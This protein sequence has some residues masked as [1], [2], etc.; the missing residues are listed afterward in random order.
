MTLSIALAGPRETV[1]VTDRRLVDGR[2]G[3]VYDEEAC[4]LAV[5]NC[6]DARAA[7]AYTGLACAKG[8]STQ[9]WLCDSLR[10]AA[11]PD[12]QL[13]PMLGRLARIATR[14]VARLGLP[15]SDG[16]LSLIFCGYHYAEPRPLA[17]LCRVTNFENDDGTAEGEAWDHFSV[18]CLREKLKPDG[19]STKVLISG[20]QDAVPARDHLALEELLEDAKPAN[21]LVG[22]AIEV[23]RSAAK[24][25]RS[26]KF[27]GEQCLSAVIPR[28]RTGNIRAGYHSSKV[29]YEIFMPDVVNAVGPLGL[30]CITDISLKVLPGQPNIPPLA[31]PK[32]RASQ[33][34][35]CGSGK[36]YKSCHG[37]GLTVRSRDR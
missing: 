10:E 35:P 15:R 14:D 8:F 25:R 6:G 28:S 27:I 21:A 13:R 22:K 33:P 37:R 19:R 16:R 18:T 36:K 24:S 20:M 26:R 9:R 12:F 4:K 2:T 11:G 23:V 3:R 5:L 30:G 29:K 7:V 34:C 1:L 17:F 31:V 32:V